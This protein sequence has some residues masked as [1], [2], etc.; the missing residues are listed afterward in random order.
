MFKKLI[1]FFVIALIIV[2]FGYSI[3]ENQAGIYNYNGKKSI[4]KDLSYD[5]TIN[6]DGSAMVVEN[7]T[8]K[9]VKGE[10]SRGYIDIEGQADAVS[11]FEDGGMLNEIENFDDSRPTDTFAVESAGTNTR[12]EWYY[13]GTEGETKI[14]QINYRISG[15]ATLYNDCADYFQKYVSGNNV[16]EIKNLNI[17]VHLPQGAN[18]ENTEIWA[19]GPS[20][21]DIYFL[22]DTNVALSMKNVPANR[23]IEA[24]FLMPPDVLQVNDQKIAVDKYEE[25]LS[26]ENQAS[27]KSDNERRINGI[28]NIISIFISIVI[29]LLPI[30]TIVKYRLKTKP[31]KPQMEPKYYRDL[32]AN[33]Y[34][35]EL[36]YLMNHYKGKINTSQQIS[37]TL[38][39]LINKGFIKGEII[40]GSGLVKK[41]D[42]QFLKNMEVNKAVASH[43]K[44]LMDFL[45]SKVGKD[46]KQVTLKEL[47]RYCSNK[48]TAKEAYKFYTDFENKVSQIVE[49][50]KYFERERNTLPR[51]LIRFLF[52]NIALMI[53]PMIL[54]N[55]VDELAGTPIYYISIAGFVSFLIVAF[56][57]GKVRPLLTQLGEDQR[58]L[59]KSF[60]NFLNDFTT[61]DKKEL[62]ELFMWEK[63]LIYATILGSAQKLLKQLYTKY[64]ELANV[65]E[66]NN[67]FYLIND[68]NYHSSYQ[69][70]ND[71]GS[72]IQDAMRDSIHIVSRASKGSGGGFSSGGNDAGGGAGGSSGGVD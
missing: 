35:A 62:P 60:R 8:Y 39:D 66:D 67:L 53:L 15:S 25:L 44:A 1:T 27:E 21:G 12:V 31:L 6:S 18:S 9:F 10:F 4:L 26:M 56:F 30:S 46:N 61:F 51:S 20:G 29:I 65:S 52:I 22:D 5:V 43:E 47:K 28:V 3:Y 70:F 17:L 72:T 55:V 57:G 19:H 59:W 23:Y 64:P 37:A 63:Y 50:R 34:P 54:M 32:P 40:K 33:I 13:R 58:A 36:D 38:L 69:S 7:R 48:K 2:V 71:I 24:R 49:K 45:F 41:K 16:Y 11:V 68:E 42:T 14:F